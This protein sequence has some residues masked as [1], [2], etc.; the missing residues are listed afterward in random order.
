MQEKNCEIL[1]AT[2]PFVKRIHN[3]VEKEHQNG[4]QIVIAGDKNHPEVKGINGWCENSAFIVGDEESSLEL[5]KENPDAPLS[6]V[7]QTTLRKEK[8]KKIEEILKKYFTNAIFFDTICSVT[9]KRQTEAENLCKSTEVMLVIGGKDSSNTAKLFGIC[10]KICPETVW[11][12]RPDELAEL[13]LI[14]SAHTKVGIAA[15]ASTPSGVIQEVYKTMSEMNENFAELFDATEIKTL[16][17]GDTVTGTVTSVTDAEL[18]LDFGAQVTGLIKAEQ[19]TDVL[20]A[21]D[22]SGI[23]S[24][25][26]QR[27]VRYDY[28]IAC[29]MVDMNSK[30]EIVFETPI[31]AVIDAHNGMGQVVGRMAMQ[32]AIEKAKKAGMAF[33]TVRNSTHYG[34]AGYY[35]KMAADQGFIGI[36]FPAVCPAGKRLHF[37]EAP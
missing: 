21:A 9:E 28:E 26:V 1:D 22:L 32:I 35:A 11:I 12:E 16:N 37:P 3:I 2:C 23:E 24:H 30:P 19:I 13:N 6:I 4:R 10:K 7:A 5:L 25:G 27:M 36:S 14:T 15:G 34:I 17:T 33:V 29:G 20:L 31:S 8:A 18:Y